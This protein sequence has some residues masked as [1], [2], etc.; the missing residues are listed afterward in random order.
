M[1][2]FSWTSI[3]MVSQVGAAAEDNK[4]LCID[5]SSTINTIN[6]MITCCSTIS[7]TKEQWLA[8]L[9]LTMTHLFNGMCVSIQAPFYPHEAEKKGAS[10]TEYGLVFG[11]FELTVFLVS[12]VIG[13]YLPRIGISR[14]FSGGITVTG[15]MLVGFGF[16]DRINNGQIFIGLCFLVRIIEAFGNSAFLAASFTMVAQLFPTSVATVFALVEMSFGVGMIVGPT[17]GGA[18]F[19]AGGYTAPFAT[20]GSILLL[21]AGVSSLTLPSLK[22]SN[23]SSTSSQVYGLKQA[24]AIPSVLL[25][26]TSVFSASI[27]IGTLSATL[28]RHLALF[29]LSPLHIGI[30]FM[31][32]GV[33]YALPNPFWGWMSDKY[34]PKIFIMIGS[35][36]LTL[37]F[38][39]I[40][41]VP[42]TGLSPSYE[43]CVFSV[44]IA[45]VGLGA[46]LVAAFSEAQKSAVKKGFPDDIS[47]YSLIS[48]IWTSAFALGAFV[49]PTVSGALFDAVGFEWSTLFTVSWNLMVCMVTMM[50]LIV[51]KCKSNFK[52]RLYHHLEE[53]KRYGSHDERESLVSEVENHFSQS[54]GYQSI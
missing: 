38:L 53:D 17:V 27:A 28:E 29:N 21:Q 1:G 11:I 22:E 15:S 34:S 44:I 6:T 35:F 37:G 32:H 46:Q 42:L 3:F 50:T 54:R 24:L 48:S 10:A 9:T 16:L 51:M 33:A 14:A 8:L 52:R 2:I 19:Q 36:L 40:G 43:L 41:P 25:A 18:L 47:T 4:E 20:L 31:M 12:P 45:G 5:N 23:T 7:W 13:K 49:G 30:F 39:L 26:I